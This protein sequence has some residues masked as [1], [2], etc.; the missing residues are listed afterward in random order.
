MARDYS[1]FSLE[2]LYRLALICVQE[3]VSTWPDEQ[4][5]EKVLYAN[6]IDALQ[7][8]VTDIRMS[9]SFK[10]IARDI[11]SA[12]GTSSLYRQKEP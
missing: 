11:E 1:G 7:K 4:K 10:Q 8:R 6:V 5:T 3:E 12:N 9:E 2:V